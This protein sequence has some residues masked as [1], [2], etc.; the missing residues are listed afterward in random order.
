MFGGRCAEVVCAHGIVEQVRAS[1]ALERERTVRLRRNG[2]RVRRNGALERGKVERVRVV[3][4][5]ERGKVSR[6]RGPSWIVAFRRVVRV[7][8]ITAPSGHPSVG[9]TRSTSLF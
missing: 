3:V 5:R 2:V 6:E 1:A 7:L 4:E 9:E 8:L